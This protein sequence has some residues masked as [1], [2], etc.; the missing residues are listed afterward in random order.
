MRVSALYDQTGSCSQYGHRAYVYG[1]MTVTGNV[2]HVSQK[3]S[4]ARGEGVLEASVDVG[5]T[6]VSGMPRVY[7]SLV[8]R[9]VKKHSEHAQMLTDLCLDM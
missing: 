3:C 5:F 4:R 2:Q 9:P 6:V 8:A 7:H 1:N